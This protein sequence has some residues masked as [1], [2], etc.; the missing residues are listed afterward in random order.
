M[1]GRLA[2]TLLLL[3]AVT[4]EK[5][6]AQWSQTNGPG[7]ADVSSLLPKGAYLFAGTRG[8]GV[9]RSTDNGI[10]WSPVNGGLTNLVVTSLA[11]GIQNDLLLATSGGGVYR[12][13]NDGID[14]R[15]ADSGLGSLNVNVL[16][17][18]FA[19]SDSQCVFAGTDGNGLFR[20]TNS[21]TTWDSSSSGLT[22]MRI[23]T[24]EQTGTDLYCGTWGGGL[25]RSI[26][27]GANWQE[28]DSGLTSHIVLAV[29]RHGQDLLAATYGDGVFRSTNNGGLWSQVF[30]NVV[31]RFLSYGSSVFAA[32]AGVG[33]LVSSDSGITW[34]IRNEGLPAFIG[35]NA[36]CII[37]NTCF[38]GGSNG[39]VWKR[40]VSD[41]VTTVRTPHGEPSNEFLLE[42]NYPNPF[43]PNTTIRYE[44][45]RASNVSLAVYDILGRDVA[46]LLNEEK[47]A[48]TY[49][50]QWDASGVSSGVYFFR[51]VAVGISDP[52][53]TLTRT[54]SMLLLK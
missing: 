33:F 13:T 20:S 10:D 26:N 29:V 34:A 31:N 36:L 25:F 52:T 42:Q 16:T 22:N 24:V 23:I 37:G 7:A 15:R 5:S 54:R 39:F 21:S 12:S 51:L 14:W 40:L 45:P 8:D 28:H 47:S 19:G 43:N 48:G 11:S 41:L 4:V 53:R 50:V 38:L 35:G 44:L 30:G 27:N 32:A 2:V 6:F 18:V 1:P 3:C 46:T 49:T 9:F 17:T